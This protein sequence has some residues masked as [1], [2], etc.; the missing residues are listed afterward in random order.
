MSVAGLVALLIALGLLAVIGRVYRL[1]SS[2]LRDPGTDNA[3]GLTPADLGADALA[4]RAPLV[5]FSSAFC[6][7]CVAVRH[8]LHDVAERL[9]GVEAVEVDAESHLELV[10]R[11]G[12]ASPRRPCCSTVTA[13]N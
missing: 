6:R 2:F 13:S 4:E 8:V 10:R 3:P 12:V 9:P 5:H 7:P 11:L 1:R